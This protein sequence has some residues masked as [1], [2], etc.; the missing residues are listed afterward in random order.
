MPAF[1]TPEQA[2]LLATTPYAF[3][4]ASLVSSASLKAARQT[5]VPP[6]PEVADPKPVNKLKTAVSVG[7]FIL[8]QLAIFFGIQIALN[9]LSATVM[10]TFLNGMVSFAFVRA[11]FLR[12]FKADARWSGRVRAQAIFTIGYQSLA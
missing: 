11:F 5:P 3:W 8:L 2:I 10:D 12:N 9:R 4:I 1:F 7:G 6:K